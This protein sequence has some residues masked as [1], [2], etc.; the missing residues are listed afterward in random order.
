MSS[1]RSSRHPIERLPDERLLALAGDGR[2]HAFE[3]LVRRHRPRLVTYCV[4]IGLPCEQADDVVQVSLT[5]AWLAVQRGARVRQPRGWLYRI[6]HNVAISST[7]ARRELPVESL[8]AAG[9]APA[10]AVVSEQ[11][12]QMRDVLGEVAA[13]PGLQ[14]E[15]LVLTV[16]A[17]ASHA[18]A[19]RLLGVSDTAVRG[20]VH[21]ARVRLR[22]APACSA[23]VQTRRG[24][25]YRSR[26][27]SGIGSH[28]TAEAT[29][30][31]R[32]GRIPGSPSSV[33]RRTAT[34]A[35][36]NGSPLN[37]AEP[38]LEQ[39]ILGTPSGGL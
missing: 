38:Q 18:Q 25:G 39:K 11:R 2:A 37:S 33:P 10:T 29:Y 20:L 17:G 23:A 3:A 24:P 6:V 12:A 32:S 34:S 27:S 5:K 22:G 13:L 21:R 19:A 7:R 35:S 15:A 9:E 28:E 26:P 4:G 30:C 14:R 36:E 1:L 16:I 8:E 31:R